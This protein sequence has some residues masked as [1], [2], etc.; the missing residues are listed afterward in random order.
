M[1][2]NGAVAQADLAIAAEISEDGDDIGFD[3]V[4]RNFGP[5]DA[6]PV[7]ATFDLWA[8]VEEHE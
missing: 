1:V 4:V 2:Q 7:R 8:A 3:L 6:V 5:S